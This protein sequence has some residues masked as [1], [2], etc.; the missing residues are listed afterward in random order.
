[1]YALDIDP[2]GSRPCASVLFASE[3][4]AYS[5]PEA[6]QRV[7]GCLCPPP[8]PH[9]IIV[10]YRFLIPS[11]CLVEEKG[12]RWIV[13]LDGCVGVGKGKWMVNR[14]NLLAAQWNCTEPKIP[15]SIVA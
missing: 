5:N 14:K 11:D 9:L 6:P 10:L 3:S 13:N 8:N 1:M 2:L 7:F 4:L 12:E 15:Y